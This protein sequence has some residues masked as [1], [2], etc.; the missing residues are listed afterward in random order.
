MR[1]CPPLAQHQAMASGDGQQR[2]SV[3]LFVLVAQGVTAA[4]GAGVLDEFLVVELHH[5][6][7]LVEHDVCVTGVGVV[8]DE[9]A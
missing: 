8:L 9:G 4:G 3:W 6:F 7:V 1:Q 5:G 2:V